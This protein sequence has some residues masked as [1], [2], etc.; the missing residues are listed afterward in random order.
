[1]RVNFIQQQNFINNIDKEIINCIGN[2]HIK[3]IEE[4]LIQTR[5]KEFQ[6]TEES[7]QCQCN[8][9]SKRKMLKK[10]CKFEYPFKQRI[11]DEDKTNEHQHKNHETEPRKTK[12]MLRVFFKLDKRTKRNIKIFYG[13]TKCN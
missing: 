2:Q 4:N 12:E 9:F 7:M 8:I 5:K 3:D 13:K 11:D 6:V 1:M 10:N